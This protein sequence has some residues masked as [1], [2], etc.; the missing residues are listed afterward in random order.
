MAERD[1]WALAYGNL[2]APRPPNTHLV[3]ALSRLDPKR[4]GRALDLGCGSGRHLPLLAQHGFHPVGIDRSA[5]AVIQSRRFNPGIPLAQASALAL[6]FADEAF[7]FVLAWGVLFHLH[8]DRLIDALRDIRRVLSRDGTT[9]LHALD[10]ADWRRDP[11]AGP[12]HRRALTS[13]HMDGVIDSFYTP[14][15]IAAMIA[16]HFVIVSREMVSTQHDFGQSAEWVYVVK[17]QVDNH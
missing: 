4:G 11:N 3:N 2:D 16:P 6:P 1:P 14:E 9:I 5:S 15:E 13:T 12:G 7:D 10:P 17:T 8:P